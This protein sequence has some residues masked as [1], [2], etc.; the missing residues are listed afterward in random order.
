MEREGVDDHTIRVAGSDAGRT[1][2]LPAGERNHGAS[3]FMHSQICIINF[4]A[5]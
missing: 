4:S 2:S 3:G 5:F 1:S